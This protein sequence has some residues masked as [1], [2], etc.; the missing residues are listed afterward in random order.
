MNFHD[1]DDVKLLSLIRFLIFIFDVK[2]KYGTF[3]FCKV[4]FYLSV[5]FKFEYFVAKRGSL[6][7]YLQL[8]LGV[9]MKKVLVNVNFCCI[10]LLFFCGQLCKTSVVVTL[11][12]PS[13]FLEFF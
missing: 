11:K 1:D 3:A 13:G 2:L 4:L 10:S 8:Q 5:V 12:Y 6:I 7:S 9:M